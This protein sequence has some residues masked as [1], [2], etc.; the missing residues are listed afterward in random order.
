MAIALKEKRAVRGL[1][2][3]AE[4]PD[5]V[6]VPFTPYPTPI[7]DEDGTLIGAVNMLVDTTDQKQGERILAS[8]AD[9]QAAMFE[10]TD[11]LFR[12]TSPR[13]VHEAAL[14][15]VLRALRCQRAAILLFDAT[16]VMRFVAWRGLS[17]AY[18]HAVDG[19]SPWTRDTLDPQA[20]C[21]DSV[22]AADLDDGL[23]A[24]VRA[25]GIGA[26]AFVPLVVRGN[27]AGKFMAYYDAPHVFSPSDTAL[28]IA[29]SRQLGFALARTREEEERQRA[30]QTSRLLTA[31]VE[32]SDDAI[33]SK[34]LDGVITS[35]NRG[36]ERLFGYASDEIL[37]KPGL[38]LIPPERHDEE[39]GILERIRRGERVE[40]YE[41]V[42]MRKDGTRVDLSL[43]VSPILDG[44]GKV[45][46]ASKIARDITERK[47]A[48]LHQ[49]FLTRELQ[50]R[51]K[52]LFAVLQAVVSRSF[53]GKTTIEDAKAAALSRLRAFSQTHAMLAEHNWQ[54]ADLAEVVRVEM[55]SYSD[56]V[57][58]DGPE[59]GLNA[60]AAQNFALAL[61]E[62]ATNA[63]KYGALSTPGGRVSVVWAIEGT[64]AAKQFRFRWLESG[65]PP[66]VPPTRKGFGTTVLEHVMSDYFSP[67]VA[68]ERHGYA[69]EIS[70]SF[71]AIAAEKPES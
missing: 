64:G 29:I 11:S 31:I 26:L 46:G 6:R 19:H 25:E 2:A 54:G 1:E 70:G 57:T 7:F 32:N 36:A 28:A 8:R 61:H 17:D 60:K 69:Y 55:S 18:R 68:Y 3:V 16:G 34:D 41:T 52:N 71:D 22:E 66:V 10:F 43:T 5:G 12:A 33:I 35:W 50:H 48:Q 53:E 30:E 38:L 40:H 62:L 15:A 24:T 45:V 23:K 67:R 47:Q 56:R 13:E 59:I 27:L 58:M 51:T 65:G 39:P 14:T 4:R 21:I 63:V 42:R 44:H 20:I 37:G 49:E 9:E